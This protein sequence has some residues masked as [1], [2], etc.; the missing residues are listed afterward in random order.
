MTMSER[1]PVLVDRL[2]YNHEC[3]ESH[4]YKETSF[5]AF[6]VNFRVFRVFCGQHTVQ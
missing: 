5:V 2:K 4:E 3:H 6:V 1:R